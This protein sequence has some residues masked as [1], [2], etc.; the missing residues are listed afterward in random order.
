[1]HSLTLPVHALSLSN[2]SS[3]IDFGPNSGTHR[4]G[5]THK[6]ERFGVQHLLSLKGRG[7][8]RDRRELRK[9]A[10]A[11]LGSTKKTAVT[12]FIPGVA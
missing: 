4:E 12:K 6:G 3:G 11:E 7:G 8:A 2:T 9:D 5:H 10:E 1:M